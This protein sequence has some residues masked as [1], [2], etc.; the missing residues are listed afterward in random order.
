MDPR[1]TG[2]RWQCVQRFLILPGCG[3]ARCPAAHAVQ[4]GINNN[5][6]QPGRDRRIAP[7]PI[8]SLERCD[9]RILQ[10]V[11]RLLRIT[12]CTDGNGPEPVPMPPE[13]LAECIG[14]T[15]HVPP[16]QLRVRRTLLQGWS[17]P[18]AS[19]AGAGDCSRA[20]DRMDPSHSP[21]GQPTKERQPETMCA[22]SDA[23]LVITACLA[24]LTQPGAPGRM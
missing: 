14:I 15:R 16:E 3:R 24:D 1:A 21:R 6:V 9:H 10:S 2:R 18:L 20:R 11:G 7:K 4:S 13:Q 12:E 5:P 17:V 22:T 8:G 23:A 19:G